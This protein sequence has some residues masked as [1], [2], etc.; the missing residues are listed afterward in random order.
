MINVLK[1]RIGLRWAI[2]RVCFMWFFAFVVFSGIGAF[3]FAPITTY[4]FFDD[5]RFWRYARL[6][7]AMTAYAYRLLFMMF[8]DKKWRF[9]S[10]PALTTPPLTQ[11]DRRRVRLSGN[12]RNGEEDCGDCCDCCLQ[13]KCPLLDLEKKNCLAYDSFFWQYFNCGR[14]PVNQEHIDYYNCTKW[15]MIPQDIKV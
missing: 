14:F 9:L 1:D 10:A 5:L 12:W 3:L 13:I 8:T 11:P 7:P 2:A 15:E 6:L 4:Y